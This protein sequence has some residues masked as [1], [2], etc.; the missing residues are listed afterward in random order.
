MR[1]RLV[2]LAFGAGVVLS[3]AAAADQERQNLFDAARGLVER[4]SVPN[5]AEP[6]F[7]NAQAE[8]ALRDALRLG[9]A[10]ATTRLG[11]EDGFWGDPNLRIP[12]PGVLKRTQDMLRPIGLSGA[13]DDLELRMNRAAE[14]AAPEAEALLV[15]AIRAMTVEDAIQ[16]VQGPDDSATRYL[17]SRTQAA[18]ADRF[19]PIIES[20]L[21]ETGAVSALNTAAASFDVGS[22]ADDAGE[23]LTQHVVDRALDGLFLQLARE[24]AD[25][26]R[27]PVRRTTEMLQVVFGG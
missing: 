16:I 6:G 4:A 19:T 5:T 15:D 24:E 11:S 20:A 8:T 22:Y 23:G 1:R 26:R 10:A 25:I 27:S 7:T 3:G 2:V 14:T 17:Q 12:L 18:L 9:A 21:A 13:I